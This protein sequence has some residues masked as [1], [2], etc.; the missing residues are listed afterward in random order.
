VTGVPVSST[1]G[2]TVTSITAGT[3]LSGGTIT[4][5][6]TIAVSYGSTAGTATEGNDSRLS[7]SRTPSGS[8]GGDLTGTYPNPTL[9]SV[10][11]A[12]V[13]VGSSTQIPVITVNAKGQIT[14]LTTALSASGVAL[15][16]SAPANLASSAAVGIGNTAARSDHQHAFPTASE[17]G[18]LGATASAGGDLT[19]SYPNPTLASITTAQTAVGS[20]TVIPVLTIDAK[21]RITGLTTASNPQ[22]TVTSVTGGTGLSGGTITGSGTLAVSYGSTAGTAAQGNDSRLSDSRTPTGTAGG[23]LAG[24]YPN[25]TINTVPVAKGG[26]GL[27]ATPANGQIPIGNATGYTLAT[28]T[29]GSNVSITNAAGAITINSSAGASTGAASAF[30]N[31]NG[32]STPSIRSSFNVSSITKN[33]TGDYTVNF[34]TALNNANYAVV[35][36][37]DSTSGNAFTLR[38]IDATT[39]RTVNLVRIQ[40]LNLSGTPVDSS[41]VQIAVFVN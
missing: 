5:S 21:G 4:N 16:T 38:T 9:A 8:A 24:T 14:N 1:A 37:P 12:Q 6:G 34:T 17:V 25:P 11:T 22:G 20:S 36:A 30:V 32:V 3:G 18:A 41:I 2:G 28:L 31:F 26:T 35:C 40:T 15:T 19:G 27:T 10:T 13:A 7:D 33:G 29:A 39:A 23:D